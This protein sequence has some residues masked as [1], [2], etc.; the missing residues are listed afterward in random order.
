MLKTVLSSSPKIPGLKILSKIGEGG[1]S[2]VF[3][4]E[5]I[6]L[7]RKVAVKVMRFETSNSELDV[8]RFKHEAKTIAHLNHPN[9]INI[10]NIGQTSTGEV[11]FTMPYLNHGDFSNYIIENE[12][13]FIVL[14]KSICDGLSFAHDR[15]VIH[16]DIKPENL[17]FDEFGNVRIADFGI[18]ITKNGAR[19]TQE[20][21]I[22]GSAQYMSPEQARSLK[23]D[24]HTDIYSLGIVIYERLTGRVP[25]DS[26]ESISILVNHVSTEPDKLPPKM[27]HWQHLIDKCLAKKPEDRFQSMVELKI[28]LNRVPTNSIQRTNNSIQ[29]AFANPY[30][31]HLVWFI[32]SIVILI[33][34]AIMVSQSPDD[35]I[36]PNVNNNVVLS[37]QTKASTINNRDINSVENTAIDVVNS[38]QE[39]T[40]QN[41][42]A[43]EQVT[44]SNT[45]D[46]KIQNENLN[47]G[48]VNDETTDLNLI[49][50]NIEN[51][52]EDTNN[53]ID[54]TGNLSSNLDDDYQNNTDVV[55]TKLKTNNFKIENSEG[56]NP[57]DV[58]SKNIENHTESHQ[59]SIIPTNRV[60]ENIAVEENESLKVSQTTDDNDVNLLDDSKKNAQKRNQ[61]PSLLA[62]A[63]SNIQ[64]YQL[65]IPR[66][67][68]AVDQLLQVL[69][70]QTDN[71]DAIDGLHRIGKI[72]FNLITSAIHKGNYTRAL[73]HSNTV[74]A[75]NQKSNNINSKFNLQKSSIL[76]QTKKIHVTTANMSLEQISTL[77][78]LIKTFDP[79]H[80]TIE[81]LQKITILKTLPQIGEKLLDNMGIETVLITQ[82]LAATT[83]E[84]TL[85]HYKEFALETNRAAAKCRHQGGGLGRFFSTITWK[86]TRFEQNKNHPV[87]CVTAK[88]ARA[89]SQWL[90]KKTKNHYRLPTKQEWMT[91]AAFDANAFKPCQTANIA[92]K[93]AHKTSIKNEKYACNDKFK[94]TAPVATFAV[95]EI[96]VFDI[97]GNVSEWIQCD[98]PSCNSAVAMGSS[99]FN[100]KQS[101]LL[102]KSENM[103]LN[104]GYTNIG[105][106]LVRDL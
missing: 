71:Q 85:E 68:N 38:I 2:E 60:V 22:V 42:T 10:Y 34:V 86:Q 69:S 79:N 89:Y 47:T 96:G 64:S 65:S 95:N 11:F 54:G 4:A 104:I 7:K 84:I 73:K 3:L 93:E 57:I 41:T 56:N 90:N 76:L 70:L 45:N 43:N 53:E 29:Q 6:S 20:H 100:G 30:G 36:N 72:Y 67:N 35:I 14:L 15:D 44:T 32:P 50:K 91:L 80:D 55:I 39:K 99:W 94:F 52:N 27:R 59:E 63:N 28:A 5:Q 49:S 1:M 78:E 103:K 48:D 12:E 25:F 98:K 87:V 92:G 77:S 33:I 16:R 105:F 101:N 102:Q 66:N 17:L 26:E 13:E 37:T 23:V 81:K 19:M 83:H 24:F 9:I 106:R 46:A 40:R 8:Q 51:I 18:A 31:K 82:S 21:Q 75:F 62:M 61:I 74:I 58:S 88:D 97:Q